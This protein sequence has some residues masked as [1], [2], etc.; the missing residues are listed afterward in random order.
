MKLAIMQPYFFPY[1]GYFSLMVYADRFICFDTAQ[2]IS[3]GWINRNRILSSKGEPIYMSVPIKKAPRDT[4]IKDIEIDNSQNWTDKI[5]GQL[6]TYKRKAPHY[7]ESI[8]VITEI[9]SSNEIG[10]LSRLN[11]HI[12][13]KLAAYLEIECKF[14]VFSEMDLEI[15]NAK[16]PDEW[17]LNI[18]KA[19]GADEYVNPPGGVSFFDKTKYDEANIKLKFLQS[20]LKPYRQRIGRWEPGLSIV[21]V[22]MFCDRNE[23]MDMLN[24]YSFI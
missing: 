8:D 7:K 23:I 2:Y 16:K 13:M 5:L 17:A 1:V 11:T 22:M 12:I 10:S 19:L 21:D 4:A 14:D 20:N 9:L 15:E 6:T 18:S 3:R 24:D